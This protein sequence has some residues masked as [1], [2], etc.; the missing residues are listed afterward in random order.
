MLIGNIYN[1]HLVRR[2]LAALVLSAT[3]LSA[4]AQL[5][6]GTATLFNDDWRFSLDHATEAVTALD[7][8]QWRRLALPHDWSIEA[9]PSPTLNACTGYFPGGIAWYTK[10]FT[11]N[12]AL[13]VHY[14]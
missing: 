8:S 6:M 5:S 3:A 12:D 14:I 4:A 13:P 7:D 11:I 10:H 9:Q 2:V 1:S